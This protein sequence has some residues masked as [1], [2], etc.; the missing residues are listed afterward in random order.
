MMP[1]LMFS[2]RRIAREDRAVAAACLIE[3]RSHTRNGRGWV[4]AD[5]VAII[6]STINAVASGRFR[7]DFGP[8]VG[9]SVE[10]SVGQDSTSN[11]KMGSL[12]D[13][14]LRISEEH[15]VVRIPDPWLPGV[16]WSMRGRRSERNLIMWIRAIAINQTKGA[17]PAT[18]AYLKRIGSCGLAAAISETFPPPAGR[19]TRSVKASVVYSGSQ[20]ATDPILD[21]VCNARSTAR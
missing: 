13:L 21:A 12:I 11:S 9:V 10:R 19:K 18:S 3:W 8:V 20:A 16:R 5:S 2:F 15:A 1:I 17:H 4:Y 7:F 6:V 14:R